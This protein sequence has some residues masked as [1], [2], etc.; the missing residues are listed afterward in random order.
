MNRQQRRRAARAAK[1]GGA[2]VPP[3]P[4]DFGAVFQEAIGHHGAG[5]IDA[6]VALYDRILA[7]APD[8]PDALHLKGVALAQR[9]AL[10][11]G[12]ALIRAAIAR[13][14]DNVDYHNNLGNLLWR[15]GCLD[16]AE[17][18]L[19]RA[20]EVAPGHAAAHNNLGNV[21]E[22]AG[23][24][25]PALESYRRAAALDPS[26]S[27]VH[28]NIGILLQKI[29]RLDEAAVSLR[30][31]VTLDPGSPEAHN[32]LGNVLKEL[33]RLEEAEAALRRAIELRPGYANAYHNLGGVLMD[34]RRLRDAVAALQRAVELD[35]R[36][37]AAWVNLSAGLNLL[38]R[39]EEGEAAAR[40]AIELAPDLAEAYNNLGVALRSLGYND[41]AEEAYRRVVALNPAHAQAHSNLI[42]VLDLNTACGI[43][44]HQAERRR[45]NALHAAPLAVEIRPH[46]NPPDPERR[47]RIG[48]VSAD[49][50][51]HSAAYC[52][53][54][55]IL[56]PDRD[57]FDVVCYSGNL[58]E[59][60]MTERFRTAATLWR[61]C[62]RMGDAALAEAI[63][64]D[65]IDILVDLSGHTAGNRLLVFARKPAPVQ[66]SAWGHAVGTG[67]DAMD[68]FLTDP[69]VVP[70]DEVHHYV[71][72]IRYLPSLLTYMPP[73]RSPEV[74]PSPRAG[75]GHVTFGSFNRLEKVNDEALSL[76]RKI[77][78]RV[79]GS[80][81]LVK[82]QALDRSSVRQHFRGRLEALGFDLDRVDLLGGTP[83]PEHLARHG[84][85]DL[86]LDPFP[87]SGGMTTA[88]SLWMGVPVVT[89]RGATVPS[90]LAAA[91][92]HA[93]SL[94]RFVAETPEQYVEI[95]VA[96]AGETEML[97]ELRAGMRDRMAATP[98]GDVER[99]VRGVEAIYRDI[100]RAWC[101]GKTDAA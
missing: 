42:F 89:L 24:P 81:L 51:Q 44:D 2:A 71:E 84:G 82:S 62:Q 36:L 23:R 98:I 40:R 20:V 30:R 54:P 14:G 60:A 27:A 13:H 74:A 67:L 4:R 45:W 91:L 12:V 70:E 17:T 61:D 76:W 25:E 29:G 33:D 90:R 101:A 9:G 34:R 68:Y 49:F 37:A 86:M 65:G 99:Y 97:A 47:L 38:D 50:R 28:G 96:A 3:P 83:Q 66:L 56:S 94:D 58:R 8:N 73:D 46:D 93:L 88:D 69:V 31:A 7:A 55:M 22:E 85:V 80:R 59:D 77:L 75:A 18:A 32:N 39:P 5:R 6:A 15:A 48:Y 10:D 78:E 26:N 100:W 16:E 52:F 21:L 72:E 63:R 1:K 87:H 11:D 92:M 64:A 57:A 35:P 43:A 41:A 53:G 95:A 79:A 19:R